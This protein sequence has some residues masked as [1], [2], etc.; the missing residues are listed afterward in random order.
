M[1]S[2]KVTVQAALVA[3]RLLAQG[4]TIMKKVTL[5]MVWML[6]GVLGVSSAQQQGSLVIP[7][8]SPYPA[9]ILDI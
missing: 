2:C 8:G 7:P 4:E 9:R 6:I 1:D 3:T 5:S